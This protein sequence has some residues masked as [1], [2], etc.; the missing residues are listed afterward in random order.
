[1]CVFYTP[2]LFSFLTHRF[3]KKIPRYVHILV[4]NLYVVVPSAL[5]PIIYG[6]RTKQ[7]RERVIRA[8][9]SK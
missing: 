5:N 9:T 2:S 3:G 8:F 7:I 4:A 6:V 1:M